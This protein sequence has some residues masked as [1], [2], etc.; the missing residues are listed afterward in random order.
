MYDKV[1][2]V[3]YAKTDNQKQAL[4]ACDIRDSCVCFVGAHIARAFL[5]RSGCLGEVEHPGVVPFLEVPAT[6]LQFAQR[7][8]PN[9]TLSEYASVKPHM[10]RINLVRNHVV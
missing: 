8:I 4:P 3:S 9:G 7:R 6:P 1:L 2:G 10:N 5:R